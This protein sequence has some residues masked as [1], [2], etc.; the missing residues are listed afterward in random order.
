MGALRDFVAD[1][2]E[3]EGAAVEP[4]E[5]DGLEVLAP[6]PLRAAMGWPEFAR[7]G[8]GATLPAARCRS[9]SKATGS[10]AS[11]PFLA[12]AAASPSGSLSLPTRSQPP[13]D[14][15]R[16]L[17]RA[18][19]LPNAVWR[20]HDA[21]PAWTRCLLLAFRYTAIS[22]EKREGLVWLGFNQGTGAVI[23]GDM[24]ARLRTLLAGE[25]DWHAP[26]PDTRRA[27]GAAWDAAAL[28]ARVRPLVEHHVRRDLEPFLNAMRRR[29]DRDRGRIHEY[30]DDLRRTAQMKLAALA[31]ASGDKAEADRKRETLR[32]AAIE[33]EYAAKLDDLRH[34]YALRVT[35][36]WM[37]GLTLFAPV[38][39][40]EVLIKRR[41]GERII[42]IDWHPAIRMMEPPPCDWGLG[43][44][45]DAPG[46]RRSS[47]SHRPERAG[48]L[49]VLRQGL[50]PR[51]PSGRL[52]TLRAGHFEKCPLKRRANFPVIPGNLGSGDFSRAS[53]EGAT[54]SF[55]GGSTA[56]DAA[57]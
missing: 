3:S 5:P 23:D 11:A 13:S 44:G 57:R 22:D 12:S 16:L 18:L 28:A 55:R 17:D 52:P 41:K 15:E 32:V 54:R 40:Y 27:A 42:R 50:V 36:D 34:N 24:L 29:L 7:L 1:M 49:P 20:L 19:D 31:A 21:K 37:Q 51:L 6:E 48:A 26:E 56:G 10:T 14:P 47:P 9:G 8:F 38:H 4:V 45:R 53:C 30:H 46:L 25:A 35:V 2:L 43:L 33:R 39:R